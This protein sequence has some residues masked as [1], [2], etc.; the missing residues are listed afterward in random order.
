[1]FHPPEDPN[2]T[3][4]APKRKKRF[5]NVNLHYQRNHDI[6]SGFNQNL[7][8]KMDP[9]RLPEPETRMLNNPNSSPYEVRELSPMTNA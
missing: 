1:M 7:D 5:Q 3:G 8:Y 9:K 2:T 4:G 6:F